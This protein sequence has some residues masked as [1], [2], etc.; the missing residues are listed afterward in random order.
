MYAVNRTGYCEYKTKR[1]KLLHLLFSEA[2]RPGKQ[3][4]FRYDL[5]S[6]TNTVVP[7][8]ADMNDY[9]DTVGE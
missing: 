6:N 7:E 5:P 4:M 1:V 2:L 3:S 8:L 9:G